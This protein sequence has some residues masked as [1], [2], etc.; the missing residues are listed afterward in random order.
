VRAIDGYFLRS[1]GEICINILTSVGAC[2]GQ[3]GRGTEVRVLYAYRTIGGPAT[4]VPDLVTRSSAWAITS[5]TQYDLTGQQVG[6]ICTYPNVYT[7]YIQAIL[8]NRSHCDDA[9]MGH[10]P[11]RMG[12]RV[13]A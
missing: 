9:L 7:V 12:A 3:D 6:A 5:N 1:R 8:T 4:N 2:Y 13:H 10:G 11:P